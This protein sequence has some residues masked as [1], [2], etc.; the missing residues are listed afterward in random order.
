MATFT[1][2]AT[3]NYGGT[4]TASNAVTGVLEDV[5][6]VQKTAVRP[7]YG[8]DNTMTYV[9]NIVNNG[10]TPYTDV[11]VS[12]DL[13]AYPF[14][15]AGGTAPVTLYPMSYVPGT[16]TLYQ[17]GTLQ[18]APTILPGT[19]TVFS[20]ITVPAGGNVVL[21]Y[22]AE[23]NEFAPRGAGGTVTNTAT[24]N[25][26]EFTAPLTASASVSVE[27]GAD[28]S[29]EKSLFPTTVRPGD[30]LTYTF[31]IRNRGNA[32]VTTDDDLTLGDTFSPRL[33]D[34]TVTLN[35][36]SLNET[37]YTAD[38]A[39]GAFT[40]GSGLIPVPAATFVQDPATGVVQVEP[41]TAV[42]TVS[43]TVV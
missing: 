19:P 27:N 28:L 31:L 6:D 35:G 18:P 33:S 40:T 16:V 17:N 23:M 2:V 39:T 30:T 29:V 1:N 10:T 36:T 42:L 8:A 38:N 7:T 11:T 37:D 24:V 14:T 5:L 12:D 4:V 3:L 20:G 21:V 41:G 22:D 26:A 25:S 34:I 15:P 9:V 32:P 43:G 13:G